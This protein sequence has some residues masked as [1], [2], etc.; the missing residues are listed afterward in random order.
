MILPVSLSATF[1]TFYFSDA[2]AQA[3]IFTPSLQNIIHGLFSVPNAAV[4]IYIFWT[5][6]MLLKHV[7]T[8]SPSSFPELDWQRVFFLSPSKASN[9]ISLRD[10]Q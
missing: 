6:F 7:N 5:C 1:D 3:H 4:I 9:T 8:L 10:S 2:K